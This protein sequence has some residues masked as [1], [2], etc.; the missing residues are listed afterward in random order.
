MEDEIDENGSVRKTVDL[1]ECGGAATPKL[2]LSELLLLLFW[3][4]R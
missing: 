4:R 1:P 3:N 2:V